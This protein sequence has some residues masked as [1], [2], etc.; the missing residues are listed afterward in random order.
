MV[1][2]Q[3]SRPSEKNES[4]ILNRF[5]SPKNQIIKPSMNPPKR[6]LEFSNAL[7]TRKSRKPEP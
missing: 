4:Y 3:R 5:E 1:W 7:Q 2:M 6:I